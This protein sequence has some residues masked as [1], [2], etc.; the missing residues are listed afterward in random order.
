MTFD[1]WYEQ[2]RRTIIDRNRHLNG[3]G[4]GYVTNYKAVFK[5]VWDAAQLALAQRALN[6]DRRT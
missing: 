4:D 5:E 1:E 6:A 2:E 3:S